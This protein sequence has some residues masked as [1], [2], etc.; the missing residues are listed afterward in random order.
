MRQFI[1]DALAKDGLSIE[2]DS[3]RNKSY[4]SMSLRGDYRL[5]LAVRVC[6]CVCAFVCLRLCVRAHTCGGFVS[7]VRAP[8]HT[9][10]VLAWH[11]A[12]LTAGT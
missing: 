9:V 5:M 8:E 4:Q 7:P 2:A 12:L 6:V 10:R 11:A 3:W 1:Q